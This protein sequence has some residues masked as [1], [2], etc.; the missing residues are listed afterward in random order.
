[1]AF[2]NEKKVKLTINFVS[3]D[4]N[5]ISVDVRE[6]S[7][8]GRKASVDV[9]KVSVKGSIVFK[10]GMFPLVKVRV[11]FKTVS[12]ISVAGNFIFRKIKQVY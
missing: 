5:F 10:N 11:Y 3:V 8:Y 7:V 2:I 4:V 1:M 9:S 6:A 12:L